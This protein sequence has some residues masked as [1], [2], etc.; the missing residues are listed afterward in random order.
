M[1][2]IL[3]TVIGLIW[4]SQFVLNELILEGFSPMGL[5]SWRMF[6]GFLTLSLLI[7]LIPSER[8]KG[9][10]LTLKLFGLLV[11]VG[12]TEAA[13]PF[14]L[15]SYAQMHIDSSVT[16]M[17]IGSIPIFTILL[18]TY[19]S[20]T[21]K[22]T[23]NEVVGMAIAFSGLIVLLLPHVVTF[24]GT[25]LAYG[26]VFLA[27]ISFS[28]SFLLLDKIPHSISALHTSRF[29]LFIYSIPFMIYWVV[30]DTKPIPYDASHWLYLATLGVFASGFVYV[31]Y[32]YLVRLAGPTFTSL[33]NYVV[34]LFGTFLGI[35]VL[36]EKFT[37]NIVVA[38]TCIVIG[39]VTI[40]LPTKR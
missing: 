22:I 40:N 17:I 3:L 4:G 35:F 8:K 31:L 16:S 18:H 39:L 2:Y 5:T 32:I 14:L 28:I 20:K 29:I 21:H 19:V 27:S 36:N 13:A 9:L 34:P 23:I 37:T 6:F 38:L 15:I 1:K 11:A 12:L 24:S 10:G 26:A 25:I 30:F 33:S 7:L